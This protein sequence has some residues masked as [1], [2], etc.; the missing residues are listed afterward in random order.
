MIL[1]IAGLLLGP[2]AG[3]LSPLASVKEIPLGSDEGPRAG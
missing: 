2:V 3:A 1:A